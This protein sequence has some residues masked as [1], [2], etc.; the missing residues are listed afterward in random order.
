[1]NV[2]TARL[3][4][5]AG[6]IDAGEVIVDVAVTLPL[7]DA[8]RAHEILDAG[9]PAPAATRQDRPAHWRVIRTAAQADAYR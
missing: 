6:M 3:T 9:R 2:T 5:I 1:V 4:R 8:A 7:A